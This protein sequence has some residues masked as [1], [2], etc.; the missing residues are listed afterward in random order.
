MAWFKIN[1]LLVLTIAGVIGGLVIG[2]LGRY[3]HFSE[4]SVMLISFPGDILMRML[5]MLILPLI[6]SS[7]IA[8]LA[9][10]DAKVSACFSLPRFPLRLLPLAPRFP[11]RISREIEKRALIPD[12]LVSRQSSGKMGS[13]A[14]IYYFATTMLAAVLGIILV[15]TIHP[16]DPTIKEVTGGGRLPRLPFWLESRSSCDCAAFGSPFARVSVCMSLSLSLLL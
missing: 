5:K 1:A 6:V 4:D 13:R 12:P 10:L 14:I 7:L 9:Q 15:L 8:G 2:M 16:G 3:A 11:D